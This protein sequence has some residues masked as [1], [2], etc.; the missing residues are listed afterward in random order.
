MD[1]P[2]LLIALHIPYIVIYD[3]LQ[4]TKYK[5]YFRTCITELSQRKFMNSFL[6]D[7]VSQRISQR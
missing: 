2:Y 4:F 3:F 1:I 6:S 7:F 5:Y